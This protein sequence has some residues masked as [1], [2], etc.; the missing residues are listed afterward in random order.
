MDA[1]QKII[2]ETV[3]AGDAP[4]LVAMCA[5]GDGVTWSGA[6]PMASRTST[7]CPAARAAAATYANPMGGTGKATIW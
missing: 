4:F 5:N 2:D 3:A 6:S 7:S 1:R